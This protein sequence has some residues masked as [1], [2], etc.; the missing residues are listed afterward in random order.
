MTK[1]YRKWRES[2]I[3]GES[4]SMKALERRNNQSKKKKKMKKINERA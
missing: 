1:A 4:Q 3:I 2:E